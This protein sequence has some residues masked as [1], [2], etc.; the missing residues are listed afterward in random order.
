VDTTETK[1]GTMLTKYR[2]N[3]EKSKLGVDVLCFVSMT[4]PV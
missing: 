4:T 2:Q 1:A 3:T